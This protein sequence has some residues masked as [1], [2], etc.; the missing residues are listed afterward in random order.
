[1][2]SDGDIIAF[3]CGSGLVKVVETATGRVLWQVPLSAP[4]ADG[5]LALGA[6]LVCAVAKGRLLAWRRL[7][8]AP[9]GTL[10]LDGELQPGLA[11]RG[12]TLLLPLRRPAERG[13]GP[14]E[15]LQA[16]D[17]RT[18]AV[19][20]EF[21]ADGSPRRFAASDEGAVYASGDESVVVFR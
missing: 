21:A 13:E 15:V 17:V 6:D 19:S 12:D 10:A 5:D 20:W 1:V 3:G 7:D 16:V 18:C 4:V 9:L 14:R 11:L 2:L 8:G